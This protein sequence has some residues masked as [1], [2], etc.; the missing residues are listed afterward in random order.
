[1]E[2]F[3]EIGYIYDAFGLAGE[4]KAKLDVYDISEYLKLKK[5]F[6]S[7]AGK[8]PVAYDV[9]SKNFRNETEA[10]FRFKQVTDRDT[11]ESLKG[12]TIFISQQDLPKLED[13]RFYYFE[14]TGFQVVDAH[15]GELGTVKSVIESQAQD[16]V[17]MEYQNKNVLIPITDEIVL[18]ADKNAKV[19]HTCMP[20]GLLD[21]YLGE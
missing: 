11:A 13:G 19:L 18:R 21:V 15:L 5:V 7:K 16:V 3:I 8:P 1:M 6:L 10:I 20:E 12:H 2:N 17:E 4:V 9:Q 14:I